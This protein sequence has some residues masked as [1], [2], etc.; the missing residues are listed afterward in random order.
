MSNSDQ[1]SEVHDSQLV[2]VSTSVDR[3]AKCASLTG[4]GDL[5]LAINAV[6]V[7]SELMKLTP[8]MCRAARGLLRWKTEQLA[9]AAGVGPSTVRRFEGGGSIRLSSVEAM[10]DA[11]RGAGLEFIPAGGQSLTGGPG[12]RTKPI[13]EPEVSAAEEA[14]ELEEP[15]LSVSRDF[16]P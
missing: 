10:F 8:E 16:T 11:L 1:C 12:L 6:S 13:A 3:S 14:L 5:R 15:A 2:C 7:R 4:R 9:V